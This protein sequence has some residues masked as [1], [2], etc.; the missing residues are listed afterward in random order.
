MEGNQAWPGDGEAFP[1]E[2]TFELNCE[3][4]ARVYLAEGWRNS[5]V[6]VGKAQWIVY[7]ELRENE[8]KPMS[9]EHS[10]G[11]GIEAGEGPVHGSY[12]IVR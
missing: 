10:I 5:S 1:E 4:L 11:E 12:R 2:E 3:G 6:A 7:M 9:S 8:R